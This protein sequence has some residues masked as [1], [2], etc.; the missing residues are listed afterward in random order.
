MCIGSGWLFRAG[1]IGGFRGWVFRLG[2]LGWLLGNLYGKVRLSG[3][4]GVG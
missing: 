2:D 4:S 1:G 3:C